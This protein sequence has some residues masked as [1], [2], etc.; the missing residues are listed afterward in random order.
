MP[1]PSFAAALQRHAAER[2]TDLA[3]SLLAA[4]GLTTRNLTYAELD[5]AARVAAEHIG[6]ARSGDEPVLLL[7]R[8]DPSCV[9]ALCGCLYGRIP[10]APVP[11]PGRG[12]EP[13]RTVCVHTGSR[14]GPLH[15]S[16]RYGSTAAPARL[17]SAR[18]RYAPPPPARPG[19][20][21]HR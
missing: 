16:D 8:T 4:D 17:R 12:S 14:R 13:A 2:P 5:Q 15:N 20:V 7:T 19:R 18:R 21:Q 11:I 1:D 3:L 10:F 9:A 6:A